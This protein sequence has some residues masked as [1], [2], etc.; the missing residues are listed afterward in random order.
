MAII[1]K[2]TNNKSWRGYREKGTLFHCWWKCKSIQPLWRTLWRFLKKLGI[3]LLYDPAIPLLSIY[4][5]KT[6]TEK[7]TCTPGSTAAPFT[8]VRTWKQPRWPLTEEWIEKMW[9]IYTMQYD[10]AIKKNKE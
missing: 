5:E 4:P 2:S 6:M 1:K 7:D 9:C 10:S 8:T 3:K